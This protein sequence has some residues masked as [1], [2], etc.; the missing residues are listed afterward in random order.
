MLTQNFKQ[1]H[2]RKSRMRKNFSR[3]LMKRVTCIWSKAQALNPLRHAHLSSKLYNPQR[4][5]ENVRDFLLR[6][7]LYSIMAKSLTKKRYCRSVCVTV[8]RSKVQSSYSESLTSMKFSNLK[9]KE[10]WSPKTRKRRKLSHS[11]SRV[12]RVSQ[13]SNH[14]ISWTETF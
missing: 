9:K 13:N 3:M 4:I 8:Y 12:F 11:N 5:Q 7:I 1:K 10:T 14:R 6:L 2:R